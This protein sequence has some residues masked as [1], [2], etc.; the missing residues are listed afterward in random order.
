MHI[1][2]ACVPFVSREVRRSEVGSNPRQTLRFASF[3]ETDTRNLASR[4]RLKRSPGRSMIPR[5]H[6]TACQRLEN[7]FAQCSGGR[8]SADERSSAKNGSYR[9]LERDCVH[10][11]ATSLLSTIREEK[12]RGAFDGGE[13]EEE[14][15]SDDLGNSETVKILDKTGYDIPFFIYHIPPSSVNVHIPSRGLLRS[16]FAQYGSF[17]QL[18]QSRD[19]PESA[20]FYL[21]V[22]GRPTHALQNTAKN[23]AYVSGTKLVYLTRLAHLTRSCQKDVMADSLSTL[24]FVP[25]TYS[26][27]RQPPFRRSGKKRLAGLWFYKPALAAEGRGIQLMRDPSTVRVQKTP[28]YVLQKGIDPPMLYKGHKFD[29]RIWVTIRADGWYMVHTDGRMRFSSRPYSRDDADVDDPVACITNVAYQPSGVWRKQW[30][31][32]LS[33]TPFY[34]SFM[35]Q[36]GNAVRDT[37]E[38]VFR[39]QGADD[40]VR[41]A[42]LYEVQN[43]V[44]HLTGWDFICDASGKVWLLEINAS[45]AAHDAEGAHALYGTWVKQMLQFFALG[46]K[47]PGVQKV[48][49]STHRHLSSADRRRATRRKSRTGSSR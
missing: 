45:P 6:L 39:R 7:V 16:V 21:V 17:F 43:T 40:G 29:V 23:A 28:P 4:L 31:T 1:F 44:Y 47:C 20:A 19:K 36:V 11:R 15:R 26:A 2:C 48:R 8:S 34:C 33:E 22:D 13:S 46:E 24:P 35:D 41:G 5:N 37:L 32:R 9:R 38:H 12:S 30:P 27:I 25:E 49:S 10:T 18:K 42:S 3:S 14:H